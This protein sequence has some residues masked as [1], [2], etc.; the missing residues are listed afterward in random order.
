MEGYP[1]NQLRNLALEGVQTTHAAY[2]D[3]D[4]MISRGLYG[5]L[6]QTAAAVVA[7]TG[8][9]DSNRVAFVMPAFEFF[10]NCNSTT[11]N[12]QELEACLDLETLPETR[13]DILHL[14]QNAQSLKLPRVLQ[15]FH[16]YNY[17][18]PSPFHGTTRY[19][20]WKKSPKPRKIRCIRSLSYEPY[21]AVRMCRD[22]PRFPE[23]FTGY[24]LNKAVW[25]RMLWRIFGYQLWQIPLEFVI[26]MPH[27]LSK[28]ALKRDE[29]MAPA[30]TNWTKWADSLPQHKSSLPHCNRKH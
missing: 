17:R 1:V 23:V 24:G 8:V 29:P 5:S 27:P 6:I 2:I 4:F 15:G 20:Y 12:K 21:V 26:H 13:E 11:F 16:S 3:S 10:S 30:M 25:I 18:G 14:F 19:E 7:N 22:L 28:A 9:D